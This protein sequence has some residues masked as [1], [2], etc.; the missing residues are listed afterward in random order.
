MNV[1]M[2]KK[3]IIFPVIGLCIILPLLF[4]GIWAHK[5]LKKAEAIQKAIANPE[6]ID[7]EE[8]LN[9]IDDSF[10]N[11]SDAEKKKLIAD[12]VTAEN[13]I[14]DATYNELKKSFKLLF[15]LPSSIR[16]KVIKKSA[17]DLRAKALKDPEKVAEFFESPAGSGALRGA[18][19]FFL[20]ELTGKQKSDSAPL[21]QAMFEIVKRQAHRRRGRS[22]SQ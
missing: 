17:D 19:K 2:K 4:G 16:K 5:R 12:P 18:S 15:T 11:M 13:L 10:R 14:A 3:K 22:V 6:Y 21:T 1:N 7:P 9:T 20:M 8:L